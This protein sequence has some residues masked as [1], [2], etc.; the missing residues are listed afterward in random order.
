[1]SCDQG[2]V[3]TSTTVYIAAAIAVLALVL[4]AVFV[5]SKGGREKRLTPLAG[6]AFAFVL[7]GIIFGENRLIGYAFLGAGVLLAL[8]DMFRQSKST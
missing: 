6:L 1:M 3:R 8:V 5:V 2:G 4:L 7:A